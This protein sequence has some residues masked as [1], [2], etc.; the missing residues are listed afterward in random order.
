MTDRLAPDAGRSDVERRVANTVRFGVIAEADY[1]RARVRVR[2]G[3]TLTDWIP[4]T[5]A[6]A[7]GD[8]TW[9]P[10][11]IGEQVIVAAP[12]GDL[13]QAVV[14]GAVNSSANAAPGDR[15][16]LS[17]TV[18]EDGTTVTYD[19]EAHAYSMDVNAA[20]TFTLTLGDATI[21]AENGKMSLSAGG[22]TIE[23]SGGGVAITS[24]ALAHNGKN[25]GDDH[26]HLDVAPGI[27][28]SGVP[29]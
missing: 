28:T 2:A 12:N 4:F 3:E 16:T 19:R 26:V 22:S 18:Y 5:T 17:R 29:A 14:M 10:V 21:T 27:S 23:I 20:G 8:R 9:H 1:A 6:R 13:R 7:G 15:A 11:E 25:V 24:A